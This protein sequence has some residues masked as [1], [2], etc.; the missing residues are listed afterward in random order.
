MTW[1]QLWVPVGCFWNLMV[2]PV[3]DITMIQ[4]QL[5]KSWGNWL[6]INW[7]RILFR[8]KNTWRYDSRSPWPPLLLPAGTQGLLHRCQVLVGSS[9]WV[10]LSKPCIGINSS[11]LAPVRFCLQNVLATNVYLKFMGF[12]PIRQIIVE[13][14][15]H[16][17]LFLIQVSDNRV[18]TLTRTIQMSTNRKAIYSSIYSQ[19]KHIL[20]MRSIDFVLK[21]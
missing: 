12:S 5:C 2:A 7:W 20:T 8:A 21:T 17:N 10:K 19:K 6:R 15:N 1:N 18:K 16:P 3:V 4:Q 11:S 9:K 13:T 14:A